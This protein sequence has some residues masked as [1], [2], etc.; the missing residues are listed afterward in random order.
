MV[1]PL[2]PFGLHIKGNI[3]ICTERCGQKFSNTDVDINLMKNYGKIL[4]LK[5]KD[6]NSELTI[7]HDSRNDETD[8]EGSGKYKLKYICF[9][10]PPLIKIGDDE[11]D[12]QSYLIYSNDKGLY[13]VV[14]TL[15]NSSSSTVDSIPNALLS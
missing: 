2:L 3:Y 11:S 15:Y 12:M 14:C 4:M 7:F 10:C 9:S 6:N 8:D 5:P 13:S 1:N